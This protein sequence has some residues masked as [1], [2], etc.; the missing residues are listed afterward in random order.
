MRF[1]G[2]AIL[3][4]ILALPLQ[5][6]RQGRT[7]GPADGAAMGGREDPRDAQADFI[8]QLR[9]RLELSEGQVEGI[10]DAQATDREIRDAVRLETRGLRDR[11]R[12]G[13]ITRDEFRVEMEGSRRQSTSGMRTYRESLES[14]LTDDQRSRMRDIRRQSDRRRGQASRGRGQSSGRGQGTR[15]GRGARQGG[16]PG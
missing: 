5:A 15:G 3:M 6:Q 12:D 10:K 13:V 11:L 1:G 2:I 9:E 7:R 8:L 16:G 4:A 14:I